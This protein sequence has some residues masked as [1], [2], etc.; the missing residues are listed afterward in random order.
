MDASPACPLYSANRLFWGGQRYNGREMGQKG[1]ISHVCNQNQS[2]KAL[3]NGKAGKR[4]FFAQGERKVSDRVWFALLT[5]E[6]S[7]HLHAVPARL[8]QVNCE[9]ANTIT[10]GKHGS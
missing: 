3:N 6:K 1:I 10:K 8:R 9:W 7:Q 2:Q 4:R 5:V